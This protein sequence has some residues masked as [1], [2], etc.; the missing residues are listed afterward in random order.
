LCELLDERLHQGAVDDLR[1]IRLRFLAEDRAERNHRLPNAEEHG[2]E[3]VRVIL[4]CELPDVGLDAVEL[5]DVV[6]Q[7][8]LDGL[9]LLR[10]RHRSH[11]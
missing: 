1:A 3:E 2:E 4:V 11:R 9:E 8:G 10:D 7:S 6:S 5:P